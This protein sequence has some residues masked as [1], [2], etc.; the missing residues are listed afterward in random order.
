MK[1]KFILKAMAVCTAIFVENFQCEIGLSIVS[2][3]F[4]YAAEI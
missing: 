2:A 4:S 1:L 3:G